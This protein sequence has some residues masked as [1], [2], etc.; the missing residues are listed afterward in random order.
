MM[1]SFS[2]ISFW[3]AAFHHYLLKKVK[4]CPDE[5]HPNSNLL[6]HY[7]S[8]KKNLA[9]LVGTAFTGGAWVDEQ[10]ACASA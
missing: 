5:E 2:R 7:V 1:S 6:T 10:L 8:S 9:T 3:N 4:I